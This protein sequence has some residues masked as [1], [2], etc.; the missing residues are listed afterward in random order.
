MLL[1]Y[2]N[3]YVEADYCKDV[4]NLYFKNINIDNSREVISFIK[5]RLE[6][7]PCI[8]QGEVDKSGCFIEWQARLCEYIIDNKINYFYLDCDLISINRGRS[9]EIYERLIPFI[10]KYEKGLDVNGVY[11]DNKGF[12]IKITQLI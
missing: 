8:S 2:M 4:W 5:D 11:F 3:G 1:I 6:I 12:N 10:Q 9:I 7:D